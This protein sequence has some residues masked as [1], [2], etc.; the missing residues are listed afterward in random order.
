[1]YM[2][3]YKNTV[4]TVRGRHMLPDVAKIVQDIALRWQAGR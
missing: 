2:L 4:R 1:M 3:Q